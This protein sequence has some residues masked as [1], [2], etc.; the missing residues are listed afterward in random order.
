[1]VD[2]SEENMYKILEAMSKYGGSFVKSLAECYRRADPQNKGIL[3][4]AF[5]FYFTEYDALSKRKEVE[6]LNYAG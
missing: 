3:F 6:K 2:K 5:D 1:M 4:N